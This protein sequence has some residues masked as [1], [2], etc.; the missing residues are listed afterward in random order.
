MSVVPEL[1]SQVEPGGWDFDVIGEH[2]EFK[3]RLEARNE[4]PAEFRLDDATVDR[5]LAECDAERQANPQAVDRCLAELLATIGMESLGGHLVPLVP[6]LKPPKARL[7]P[8]DRARLLVR[9]PKKGKRLINAYL[10][11][12]NEMTT[13][14]NIDSLAL[15]PDALARRAGVDRNTARRF[16]ENATEL[17]LL[18]D[19]RQMR[20]HW[21]EWLDN[22]MVNPE[23]RG[24]GYRWFNPNAP[25]TGSA[26]YQDNGYLY[27][28]SNCF[29]TP[30]EPLRGRSTPTWPVSIGGVSSKGRT[31][32][33]QNWAEREAWRA[34][35]PGRNP[36]GFRLACL[37]RGAGLT[38]VDAR[39]LMRNYVENCPRKA[40][41]YTVKDAFRAL[42]NAYGR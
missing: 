8:F 37:L 14:A 16:Y 29:R 15:G 3:R 1:S 17:D 20:H 24:L 32:G 19:K 2:G 9:H 40:K 21:G 7:R 10:D 22:V 26:M 34:D 36:I 38:E 6:K 5:I 39:P 31:Q 41:P 33:S 28:A 27:D 11:L 12:V 42:R 30:F 25:G 4:A 35:G 13:K 18:K 23:F